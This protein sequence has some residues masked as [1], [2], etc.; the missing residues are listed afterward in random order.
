MIDN[1]T[2]GNYQLF[3]SIFILKLGTRYSNRL[4]TGTLKNIHI[5]IINVQV[6]F[7]TSVSFNSK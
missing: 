3:T 4:R 2:L 5:H 6:K 1:V 7:F